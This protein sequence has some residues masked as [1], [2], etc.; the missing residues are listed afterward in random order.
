MS[1]PHPAPPEGTPQ[2]AVAAA[3]PG[4]GRREWRVHV[5]AHKTATTHF[6]ALLAEASPRVAGAG[7][8]V[9]LQDALRRDARG[10][11]SRP[12]GLR[13]LRHHLRRRWRMPGRLRAAAGS[14]GLVAAS[15]E[16]LL[17]YA[18]DLL[19]DRF[20]PDL[21]GLDL[22][23]RA[24]GR[25]PLTLYLSIRSYDTLMP[26]V[27]FELLKPFP[28]ARRRW[29]EGLARLERGGGGWPELMARIERRVPAAR[30]CFWRQESYA[31]DPGAIVAA[32]L[33]MP[34][35]DLPALAP[36][37]RT[38]SPS[39][40]ALAEAEALDPGLPRAE[41]VARVREIYR[42]HSEGA[43]PALLPA[44]A[45]AGLAARYA[46]DLAA[47]RARYAELGAP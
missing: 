32:F 36:P 42:R 4:G 10:A 14:A 26:S 6:Q 17:G 22:V 43:A 33:G 37:A 38:R 44:G 15:E 24:A 28:D 34:V 5:G 8:T 40:A 27:F 39:A 2:A 3:V 47:L 19:H 11:R 41:R 13:G 21:A 18:S 31:R 23:R 25:E 46:R 30:L 20:Y 1:A 16:D 29:A 9:L 45:A 35:P 7:G 12:P